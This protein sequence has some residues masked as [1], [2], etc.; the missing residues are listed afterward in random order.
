MTSK[1]LTHGA[2][3][4]V[5]TSGILSSPRRLRSWARDHS[6]AARTGHE[7]DDVLFGE[8]VRVTRCQLVAD[9]HLVALALVVLGDGGWRVPARR[10][11]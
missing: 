11:A 9:G 4:V 7:T 2:S 8:A 6:V 3:I 5:E 10:A 1:F